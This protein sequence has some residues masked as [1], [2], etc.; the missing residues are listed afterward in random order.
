MII[1]KF[2]YKIL[3][4][5]QSLLFSRDI[6]FQPFKGEIFV[7]IFVNYGVQL[8]KYFFADSE[9]Q[10]NLLFIKE[11]VKKCESHES[12]QGPWKQDKV[13]HFI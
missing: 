6:M 1:S 8:A 4:T 13:L 7:L 11:Q 10:D 2:Q 12:K 3:D 9:H 5:Q